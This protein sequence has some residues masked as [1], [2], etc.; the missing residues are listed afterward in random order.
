MAREFKEFLPAI[1]VHPPEGEGVTVIGGQAVNFWCEQALKKSPE[2][3][4]YYPFTSE[5]LDVVARQ[6]AQTLAI[7]RA[8]ALKLV[9]VPQGYAGPDRAALV[10]DEG[11]TVI[12]I[13]GGMYGVSDA[14]LASHTAEVELAD[15][16]GEKHVARIANP[17]ALI[18][19][20]IALALAPDGVR[21]PEDR[22]HDRFHLKLLIL[23]VRVATRELLDGIGRGLDERDAINSLKIL[24]GVICSKDAKTVSADDPSLDWRRAIAPEILSVERRSYP[25]LW[26]YV[27][28]EILPWTGPANLPC[29]ESARWPRALFYIVLAGVLAADQTSKAWVRANLTL[30]EPLA[31]IPGFFNLTFTHNTGVAFGMFQGE[32]LVVVLL[33]VAL[34]LGALFYTRGLN[35]AVREPNIVGGM[36]VGGALGNLLDR[37]RLGYVVDFLDFQFGTYHWYIFNVADSCICVAVAWLVVGQLRAKGKG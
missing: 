25:R 10:D 9:E 1:L 32:G 13:L 5:D 23:C 28:H 4:A 2:L 15:E 11:R 16:H 26:N 18:K 17:T 33:V 30:H 24:L 36:I 31:V 20:K 6:R 27:A 29:P 34:A 14:D 22:D 3:A 12:Q 8:T 35:W 21:T 19:G 7:A 37:A